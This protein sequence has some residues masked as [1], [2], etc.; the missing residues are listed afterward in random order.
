MKTVFIIGNSDIS[1]YNFRKE[2][3][4]RLLEEKFRV[5]IASPYGEKF[6]ELKDKG[7]IIIDTPLERRSKNVFRDLKSCSQYVNAIKKY[8]PGVVIT[9]TIKPNL[10]GSIAANICKVSYFMNITGLGTELEKGGVTSA[11]LFIALKPMLSYAKCVFFQNQSHLKM[12]RDK[13]LIKNNY[14]VVPGSGVNLEEFLPK[15]Y[16]DNGKKL[17][18]LYSGRI[19]KDKGLNELVQA[20]KIIKRKYPYIEFLASGFIE[21][22]YKEEFERENSDNYLT[23]LGFNNNI[24]ELIESCDAVILPSYHEG[25][26]NAL[27]EGAASA[28]ALIASNIPGCREAIIDSV[29]GFL[30]ESKNAG[31]IVEAVEKFA[32][33]SFEERKAMG[34]NGRKFM[35]D[36]F[37]RKIVVDMYMKELYKIPAF[38]KEL[39]KEKEYAK[40]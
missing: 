34:L 6:D 9:Y 4:E 11:S 1:I 35:E 23:C 31:S 25:M 15:E 36:K 3:V 32:A 10:Y 27:L 40:I 12:F 17:R 16:P 24:N 7:C 2:L 26:S 33:L 14:Q 18:I 21:D 13:K 19:M 37:D 30:F 20:A 28:R 8:K 29:T 38:S 5:V 22:D 39:S